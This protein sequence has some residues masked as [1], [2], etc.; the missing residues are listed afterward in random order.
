MSQ[1]MHALNAMK[2]WSYTLPLQRV[3]MRKISVATMWMSNWR[4][5]NQ[6]EGRLVP[7][8]WLV[9]RGE[10]TMIKIY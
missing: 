9:K 3:T 6:E 2:H 7:R 4:R 8:S 10:H 1:P 5:K